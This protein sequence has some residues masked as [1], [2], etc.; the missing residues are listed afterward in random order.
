MKKRDRRRSD[1]EPLRERGGRESLPTDSFDDRNGSEPAD[2]LAVVASLRESL[3]RLDSLEPARVPDV[4]TLEHLLTERRRIANRRLKRE[5]T[6]FVAVAVL[7]LTGLLSL[8]ANVPVMLPA[9]Q[10]AAVTL[11][12]LALLRLRQGKGEK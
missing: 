4:R 6:L 9:M 10:A 12:P 7:L 8:Y 5:L 2:D 1:A 11:V 3:D